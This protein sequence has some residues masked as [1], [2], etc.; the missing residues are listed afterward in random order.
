MS[1]HP[2]LILEARGRLPL[3][4]VMALL[5][6]GDRAKRS[7]RCPFHE[8]RNPSFSVLQRPDG[9]WRFRCFGCGAS[10]DEISF[11]ELARGLSNREAIR[12][13]IRLAGVEP[14]SSSR[15]GQD[16]KSWPAM[17]TGTPKEIVAL[18][19]L[20]NVSP[21]GL[22]LASD[23]GLLRFGRHHG[24]PVWLVVDPAGPVAQARR[25]NGQ[26]WGNGA[27]ALTL[28]GS[29]AAW[30]VG[31]SG[32]TDYPVVLFVEGGADLLAAH[33]FL[34]A[35]DRAT[36][37]C[38][39]GM[40][41]ASLS[42]ASEAIPLFTGKR[43][44]FFPHAD[45]AGRQSVERWAAQLAPVPG[46]IDALNLSGLRRTDGS[47]VADLNDL[48]SVDPDAFDRNSTLWALVPTP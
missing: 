24:R 10:G 3:P 46:L 34:V 40:L 15:G 48:T 29:R 16:S 5:G 43:V 33:H 18:A 14:V 44:R 22:R 17:R 31:A 45:Q 2:D 30:P 7:A 1:R 36:D 11:L 41:G 23:R 47:R 26:P 12:E 6:H 39:V 19:T 32:M 27:K 20:R 25:L 13:F 37:A 8:D 35:E 38:V 9:R 28:P 4:G 21:D 42:I